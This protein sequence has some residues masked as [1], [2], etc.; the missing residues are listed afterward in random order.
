MNDVVYPGMRELEAEAYQQG[1]YFTAG[2]ARAHRV[3]RQLLDYHVRRGRFARIRRGLY[4]IQGFPTAEHDEL[5]EAWMAVGAGDA[6]LS[7]ESALA[8][9]DLSDNIPDGVHLLVPRR[10]RGLRRPAGVAL[11]TRP[12]GE[13]VASVWRDGL[14]LTAPARTLVDV[15]DRLQPERLSMAVRQALRRGLL[16]RKQ[17]QEEAARRRQQHTIQ[18]LLTSETNR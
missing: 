12:D 7:H 18:V 9:L 6:L 15:A 3:S 17:L 8:L 11:H 16:T 2:Q 10:R 1:G 5:R 4:R 13:E 14:P